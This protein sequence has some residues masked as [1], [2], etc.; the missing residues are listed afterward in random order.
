MLLGYFG[1]NPQNP[2]RL[3]SFAAKN[4]IG[5]ILVTPQ[6]GVIASFATK[7]NTDS[8]V[9]FSGQLL[10]LDDPATAAKFLS[11]LAQ[12]NLSALTEADGQWALALFEPQN[13]RLTLSHDH[14]GAFQL[15]YLS[16]ADTVW[17]SADF[18]LLA[19]LSKRELNLAAVQ[20]YLAFS[21]VPAPLTLFTD[22]KAVPPGQM[23]QIEYHYDWHI[24]HIPQTH[25]LQS[26]S[27]SQDKPDL[28]KQLQR[29]VQ[30]AVNWRLPAGNTAVAL[31]LSG[32][33]DSSAVAVTLARSEPKVEAFH[34]DFGAPFDE[35]KPVAQAVAATLG[36][37]L[38]FVPVQPRKGDGEKLLRSLVATMPQPYGD[39]VTLPHYLGMQAVQER[40]FTLLFNG[41]GGDQL[42]AG[43][44]NKAMFT[45][46]VFG[47]N[48]TDRVA[49]YLRTFHHFYGLENILYS[50]K[51]LDGMTDLRAFVLPYL[52]DE[53]LV[54]LF[55][56]LRWTNIWMKGSGNI[57]PRIAAIAR[58]NSITSQF[59]LFD[60]SLARFALTIPGH[61]LL[62][63]STEKYLL[64]Q[65]L[66]G[67][68]P[69]S[70]I[71]R[72]KRGMGVPATE[73]CLEPLFPEIKKW[74]HYATKKRGLFQKGY[75]ALLLRGEDVPAEIRKRRVGEKLW[76]LAILELWLEIFMDTKPTGLF[77]Q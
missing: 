13:H 43:W 15:F 48:E 26:L 61:L 29:A 39:P 24:R 64:K 63:G 45:A 11:A 16:T 31:S 51:M 8:V 56:R 5:Q 60:L 59:P 38:Q 69:D 35:E 1:E 12:T 17:F 46:E 18:R 3:K 27:S 14:F 25:L 70:V 73:W 47:D 41:E 23:V 2:L 22:I 76:Q 71:D 28:V 66:R 65:T 57:I 9:G 50:R 37:N 30:Q 44:A 19:T 7:L 20:A 4:K 53:N 42:F 10:P 49:T 74:L 55:D 75:I 62:H 32:G 72:A 6:C 68:L 33:L 58:A 40:G 36:F 52:E 77:S 21:Y 54:S 34:L 67:I